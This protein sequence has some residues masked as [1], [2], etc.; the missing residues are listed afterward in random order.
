MGRLKRRIAF[1]VSRLPYL[2]GATDPMGNE[3]ETWGTSEDVGV[4]EF[5]PG[6]S[7]EPALP[8][9]DRVITT[10]MLYLPYGCPFQPHDKCVIDGAT[11]TVEGHPARWKHRR[12]GRET[13]DVVKL[14]R[15][16]G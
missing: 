14:K 7:S 11:Y 6:G 4:Y 5:D 8:G 10:P 3:V 12:T 16:E 15:V 2:P 1:Y 13:G 9:H